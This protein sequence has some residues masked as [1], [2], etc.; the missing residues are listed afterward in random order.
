MWMKLTIV[1]WRFANPGGNSQNVLQKFVRF[2]VTLDIKILR[3]LTLKV[4]FN[5]DIIKG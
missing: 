2:F 3:L 1:C 4:V 5:A